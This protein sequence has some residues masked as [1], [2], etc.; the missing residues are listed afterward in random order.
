MGIGEY[1]VVNLNSAIAEYIVVRKEG[2]QIKTIVKSLPEAEL[3]DL[4]K[5]K[6]LKKS[7]EE[8]DKK[9]TAKKDGTI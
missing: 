4:E 7:F 6:E 2:G 5:Y 9:I 3:R 8:Y 1:V